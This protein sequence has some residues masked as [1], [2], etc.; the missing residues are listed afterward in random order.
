[1]A[2][3]CNPVYCGVGAV[4]A[5]DAS[6]LN[7][8]VKFEDT[9]SSVYAALESMTP[10]QRQQVLAKVKTVLENLP[11]ND[12]EQHIDTALKAAKVLDP[13][14]APGLGQVS[15]LS[16]V[17]QVAGIITSLTTTGFAVANFIQSRKTAKDQ[18]SALESQQALVKEQL[19]AQ[20]NAEKQ[21][22]AAFDANQ[23]RQKTVADAEAQAA[24]L[25]AQ[26]LTLDTSGNIVKK[27]SAGT[28]AAIVAAGAGA[29]FLAK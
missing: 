13:R 11:Y 7:R 23:A 8:S 18:K 22:Q 5:A 24:I 20:I 25:S 26:G 9:F 16:T 12:M 28:I 17:A 3:I 29:F 10:A 4:D 19:Q 15:A 27:S 6:A 2:Y 1:M 14:R 21:Q